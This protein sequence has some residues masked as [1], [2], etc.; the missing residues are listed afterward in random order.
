MASPEVTAEQQA[1]AC[2]NADYKE[3]YGFFDPENYLYKAPKGLNRKIVEEISSYKDEPEWMREFRLKA[4]EHFQ[5]RPTPTWGGNLRQ[6]ASSCPASGPSTRARWSTTR[7][8]RTS[9]SRA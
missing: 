6:I 3:K 7:F 5:D 1:L 9:R 8:A 4:L 2:I